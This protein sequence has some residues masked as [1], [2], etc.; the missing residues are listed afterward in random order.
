MMSEKNKG[1]NAIQFK[2]KISKQFS[3]EYRTPDGLIDWE[4]LEKDIREQKGR[5]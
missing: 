4:K 1:F 2:R 5:K 3:K